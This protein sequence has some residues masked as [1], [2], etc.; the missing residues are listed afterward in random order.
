MRLPKS[1]RI[2]VIDDEPAIADSLA[3]IFQLSGYEVEAYYDGQSA[4]QACTAKAPD[5]LVSDVT[6]PGLTGLDLAILVREL[7]PSCKVLLFSGLSSSF[8]LVERANRQGHDF[9][10]LEKPIAPLLLL[11]KV[12]TELSGVT[13]LPVRPRGLRAG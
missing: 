3:A 10:I 9:E 5:L 11:E 1:N 12:A 8:D 2:I 7:W 4:L 13:R 6:M